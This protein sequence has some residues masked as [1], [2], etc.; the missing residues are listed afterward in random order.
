[1]AVIPSEFEEKEFE[2]PLYN[3]L[4]S[5]TRQLW[6]PGQVFEQYVG[7][8]RALFLYDLRLWRLFGVSL[9]PV[10]AF[11]NRMHWPFARFRR[12]PHELPNFRLNLFLQAKRCYRHSRTPKNVRALL[13][14]N[15]CWRFDLDPTQQDT[16]GKVAERL[17]NRALVVYA[18]PAFHRMT[19]LNAHTIDGT[20]PDHSTFP[21]ALRLRGHKRWYY[22]A[23]GGSG[24][25]NPDPEQ[26]DG[27]GIEELIAR[28]VQSEVDGLSGSATEQLTVLSDQIEK[29]I[30]ADVGAE[31]P[32]KALYFERL[33]QIDILLRRYDESGPSERAFLRVAAFTT[34]FNVDWYVIDERRR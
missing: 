22:T 23:P 25:A 19:Q 3:Q 12:P 27:G 24:V 11:L 15:G 9:P 34:A 2:A 30:G 26:I 8:D 29:V 18:A 7:I 5:G 10:G 4:E 14:A 6:A 33:R 17:G 21:L 31:N 20:V 28:L 13:G 32:R 1:M 16:L